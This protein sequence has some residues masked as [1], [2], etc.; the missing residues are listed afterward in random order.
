MINSPLFVV[1]VSECPP[2]PIVIAALPRLSQILDMT[3]G[4]GLTV[5][6]VGRVREFFDTVKSEMDDFQVEGQAE[7]LLMSYS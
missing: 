1:M 4:S 5:E 6:A 7:S 2:Y 3:E